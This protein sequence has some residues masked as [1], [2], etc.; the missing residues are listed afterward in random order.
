MQA[1][2]QQRRAE[3]AALARMQEADE[4][5]APCTPGGN[6][7]LCKRH[8]TCDMVRNRLADLE[9]RLAECEAGAAVLRDALDDCRT[10]WLPALIAHG[11]ITDRPRHEKALEKTKAAL[12]TTAGRDLLAERDALAARVAELE[13]LLQETEWDGFDNCLICQGKKLAHQPGCRLA[14]A[15]ARK[16]GTP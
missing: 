8:P 16:D 10:D 9:R 11:L 3:Y 15:L 1:A 2:D 6:Y 14:A 13:W 7:G 12:A 5:E 4:G